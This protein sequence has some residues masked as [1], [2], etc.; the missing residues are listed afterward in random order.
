M[1][2]KWERKFSVFSWFIPA[3]NYYY[4]LLIILSKRH[5]SRVA[6]VRHTRWTNEHSC[7]KGVVHKVRHVNW[8]G[9]YLWTHCKL[10]PLP[11]TFKRYHIYFT[12]IPVF[13][14]KIR[15]CHPSI[16]LLRSFKQFE[17]VHN[18]APGHMADQHGT[19]YMSIPLNKVFAKRKNRKT[20]CRFLKLYYCF[21]KVKSYYKWRRKCLVAKRRHS[22]I[23]SREMRS[24]IVQRLS[25]FNK[26]CLYEHYFWM[27]PMAVGRSSGLD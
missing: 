25:L 13:N 8:K 20:S 17:N 27:A 15:A 19:Y 14:F 3:E 16:L 9:G 21:G 7:K 23:T 10:L 4:F 22:K 11:V 12:Y 2:H 1:C 6:T 5:F 26:Q 24:S 18:S